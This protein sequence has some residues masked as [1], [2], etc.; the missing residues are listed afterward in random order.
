MQ[1][2]SKDALYEN[3]CVQLT[4]PSDHNIFN[5]VDVLSRFKSDASTNAIFCQ[6]DFMFVHSSGHQAFPF[7]KKI[8]KKI[9]CIE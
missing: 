6:L 5:T 2:P 7:N 4:D 8:T 3:Q 9:L 1:Y